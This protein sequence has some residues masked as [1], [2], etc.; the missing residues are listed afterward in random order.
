MDSLM[1]CKKSFDTSSLIPHLSCLRRKTGSRFTLIE[2]LVVIAIIAILAAMLLPALNSARNRAKTIT[3]HSQLKTIG[4][5][6]AFYVSDNAE[7]IYPCR[8]STA[9]DSSYWT[10]FIGTYLKYIYDPGSD[11]FAFRAKG[12]VKGDENDQ[13]KLF[14]CP[15]E[16]WKVPDVEVGSIYHR[17]QFGLQGCNYAA[18]V[19]L[20]YT[21]AHATYKPRKLGSVKLPSSMAAHVCCRM[22]KNKTN[23]SEAS[24]GHIDWETTSVKYL[25][26]FHGSNTIP[27]LFVDGHVSTITRSSWTKDAVNKPLRVGTL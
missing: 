24:I 12:T 22:N 6:L 1:K 16:I 17:G 3:C 26:A 13:R 21:W 8:K 20:G 9:G 19:W 10:N 27:C 23:S 7:W 15:M 14:R 11:R 18:N 5:C 25:S 4:S 2:L